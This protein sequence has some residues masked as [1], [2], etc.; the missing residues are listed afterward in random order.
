[1]PA[2]TGTGSKSPV[3]KLK[4]TGCPVALAAAHVPQTWHCRELSE[5]NLAPGSVAS[6]YWPVMTQAALDVEI[7]R[8]YPGPV[9]VARRVQLKVP[10]KHFPNLT[11]AEQKEFYDGTAVEYAEPGAGKFT[12]EASSA[13]HVL[14]R[15][16]VKLHYNWKYKFVRPT[17]EEVCAR[18]TVKHAQGGARPAGAQQVAPPRAHCGGCRALGGWG[19]REIDQRR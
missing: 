16:M 17:V 19:A 8:Q 13:G 6:E 5:P 14:L 2:Y 1:M 4:I 18:Y 10:G 12:D 3:S 15:R 9:Q 11:A 7:I